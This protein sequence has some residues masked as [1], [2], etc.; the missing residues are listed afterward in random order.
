MSEQIIKEYNNQGIYYYKNKEYQLAASNFRIAQNNADK[1]S[2]YYFSIMSR[3]NLAMTYECIGDEFKNN[4][5]NFEAKKYYRLSQNYV[6]MCKKYLKG[7]LLNK[8][9][10]LETRLEDKL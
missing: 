7:E 1:E 4:N 8:I 3:Y 2:N 9:I 5:A 6:K 10:K